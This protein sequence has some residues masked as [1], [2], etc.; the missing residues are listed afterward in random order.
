MLKFQRP[1][2]PPSD[3][4]ICFV[5]L[6]PSAVRN[7]FPAGT[8]FASSFFAEGRG[9]LGGRRREGMSS[10][11]TEHL[12]YIVRFSPLSFRRQ[13]ERHLDSPLLTQAS[14]IEML[15]SLDMC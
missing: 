8:L 3:C 9:E 4:L 1:D 15:G 2:W 13:V 14:D 6:C 11:N 12:L 7:I 5:H 10:R